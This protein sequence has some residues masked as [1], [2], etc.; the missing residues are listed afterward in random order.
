M[1]KPANESEPPFKNNAQIQSLIWNGKS[2]D[3]DLT[4]I[5]LNYFEA[6]ALVSFNQR[7]GLRVQRLHLKDWNPEW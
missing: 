5:A 7:L 6:Y 3:A 4:R 1:F 2:S